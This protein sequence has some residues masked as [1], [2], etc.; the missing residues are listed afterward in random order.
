MTQVLCI[1]IASLSSPGKMVCW[2]PSTVLQADWPFEDRALYRK[3]ELGPRAPSQRKKVEG[4]AAG[5]IE[6]VSISRMWLPKAQ[7]LG[8]SLVQICFQTHAQGQSW[9]QTCILIQRTLFPGSWHTILLLLRLPLENYSLLTRTWLYPHSGPRTL[10]Q[11]FQWTW[12]FTGPP[13]LPVSR[14][15]TSSL[16]ALSF[17]IRLWPF[18]LKGEGISGTESVLLSH[19]KGVISC[20]LWHQKHFCPGPCSATHS[21]CE[22]KDVCLTSHISL[23]KWGSEPP[24]STAG[25]IM[26][27]CILLSWALFTWEKESQMMRKSRL[28]FKS[29]TLWPPP[30]T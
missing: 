4:A 19:G 23:L 9:E 22:L 30:S 11:D 1:K 6:P 15:Y 14:L 27:S 24:L 7:L 13:Q 5:C 25:Y 12:G 18:L 20:Q 29:I 16:G 26:Q 17:H 21:L 10:S 2:E 28:L 3:D 8:G